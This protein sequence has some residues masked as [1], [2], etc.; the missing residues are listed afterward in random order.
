MFIR[1]IWND[2]GGTYIY[3]GRYPRKKC[4]VGVAYSADSIY[5]YC[6]LIL[7]MISNWILMLLYIK[8]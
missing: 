4:G 8:S 3:G 2:F 1:G 7:S 5:Y 6:Y